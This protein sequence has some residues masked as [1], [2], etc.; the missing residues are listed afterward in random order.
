MMTQTIDQALYAMHMCQLRTP[1][2]KALYRPGSPQSE[3]LAVLIAALDR[4]DRVLNGVE[5]EPAEPARAA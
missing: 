1:G 5:V 4:A 2:L 3:A